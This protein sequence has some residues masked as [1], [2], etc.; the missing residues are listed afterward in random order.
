MSEIEYVTNRAIS[1]VPELEKED[2]VAD[3]SEF[4]FENLDANEKVAVSDI[5][6]VEVLNFA[7]TPVLESEVVAHLQDSYGFS[8]EAAKSTVKQ[9]AD[10]DLL[11]HP[12][13]NEQLQAEA[14]A[15]EEYNWREAFE[16]YLYFRNYPYIDYSLGKEAFQRD[17]NIMMEYREEEPIPPI[18]KEYE[19]ADTIDLPSIEDDR[20]LRSFS[21]VMPFEHDGSIETGGEVDRTELSTILYYAFGETG[22]VEF[23]QQGDC[24]TKTSPSG[25][26]RH[27]TEAYVVALD[28]EDVPAGVF[29]YSVKEHALE[30]IH[31][32]DVSDE[33]VE[34]IYELQ[35]RPSYEVSFLVV[36][37]S[38][39]ER[40]MW[41]YREPRTYTV[42]QNDIGHLMETLRVVTNSFGLRTMFGHGYE[43]DDLSDLLELHSFEEPIFRYA[44]VG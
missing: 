30:E 18:Y 27:P 15:W 31:S 4:V 38:I 12:D 32:G 28:V 42:V 16:F 37:S 41:R 8:E 9:L 17:H 2:G 20:E 14:E 6:M 26:A 19:D 11:V 5:R 23:P 40:S 25:G 33:I 36:F 29:H 7:S 21:E 39:L 43:D 24:L 22:R 3:G 13:E 35:S 34:T 44:A 1:V 10:Q